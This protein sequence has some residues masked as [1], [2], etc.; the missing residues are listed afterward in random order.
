[1]ATVAEITAPYANFLLPVLGAGPGVCRVCRTSIVGDWERCFQCND[2]I[3]LLGSAPDATAFVAL[4]AK[5]GQLAHEL[6]HYKYSGRSE[7]RQRFQLGLAALLWRWLRDHEPCLAAASAV[8]GFDVVTVVPSTTA[9]PADHHFRRMVASQIGATR[10]RYTD[11]LKVNHAVD[12]GRQADVDRWEIAV[13]AK[14]AAVLVVDDTWTSG[15][16][17]LSAAAAIRRSGANKVALLAIGRHFSRQQSRPDYQA[18][19]EA[20]YYSAREL[21]WDWAECC[22]ERDR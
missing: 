20:Y 13:S 10:D 21:G 5:G 3:R 22:L 1:V 11:L 16:H 4:A 6:W 7:V 8:D 17:A 18:A 9:G 19:A 12:Q 15:G 14:G 2:A